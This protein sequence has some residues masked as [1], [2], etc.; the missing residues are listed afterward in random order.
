[1]MTINRIALMV[2]ISIILSGNAFSDEKWENLTG[3]IKD[4]NLNAIAIDPIDSNVVFVGSSKRLYRSTDSGEN[5]KDIFTVY[6]SGRINFIV[7]DKKDSKT[8]YI[9]TSNGLFKTVDS[10]SAWRRI[11]KGIG[12]EKKEV[13][14][15]AI[16]PF[17]SDMVYAG[18]KKGFFISKNKGNSWRT[19]AG[20]ME[21]NFVA[22]SPTHP[23]IF[24]IA[25]AKGIFKTTDSGKHWERVFIAK[26]EN[27]KIEEFDDDNPEVEGQKG[28][29]EINCVA[30][31]PLDT[32]KIY[33]GTKRGVFISKDAARTWQKMSSAGLKSEQVNFIILPKGVP[34]FI[35]AATKDGVFKFEKKNEL[36]QE[37][38]MG[39]TADHMNMLAFD[40]HGASLWSVG[41]GGVFKLVSQN[42]GIMKKE[43]DN[44][45]SLFANEPTAR[46]V[47]KAAI[48]YAEVSPEKI[49]AWRKGAKYRSLLPQ[50]SVSY[51]K[52]I[53]YSKSDFW[54]GPYDWGLDLKWDLAD[55]I[56]NPYQKDID[57]RS[58][59]MVQ[60][61]DD[62]LDE[63]THLYYE[64]RRLQ[65]EFLLFP[66]EDAKMRMDKKIRLQELT[67]N[68]D[69]LTD[70]YLSRR[71]Q[72]QK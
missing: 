11:F 12:S 49:K 60:L 1:M 58:R 41:D 71:S 26:Q 63:V 27:D 43:N 57:V 62:I 13:T 70:G 29:K 48:K 16:H 6:G 18:T 38:Y 10:G 2:L 32:N 44:V 59:L 51:D 53:S 69:A 20:G 3:S 5:W 30:I 19:L 17:N 52:T 24:Y 8:I 54:I 37:L 36:W 4:L 15:V 22:I 35:Y 67:S 33:L 28:S 47:Q 34:S 45:L 72:A 56:W 21:V 31:S 9:A 66:P 7:I 14:S 42:S 23:D 64:R 50:F 40:T 25:A 68:I 39:I 61:R 65:T 46:E 55:L